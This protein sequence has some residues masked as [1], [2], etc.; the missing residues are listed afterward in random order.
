MLLGAVPA[1]LPYPNSKADPDKYRAGLRGVSRNLSARL[2]VVDDTFP[3]DILTHLALDDG[4]GLVRS[5]DLA[6][7]A[8]DI[9][10]PH[11]DVSPN[12]LAFIQHS[13]GTTG[14]QKGVALT[15]S[16]VMTQLGHLA[17]VLDL[18]AHDRIYSW[19]PLYHDMGLVA[20]FMLPLACHVPVVMQ[21]PLDWVLQPGTM[22][23]LI[24]DYRC[25]VGW[26]PNFALQFLARRVREEDR[27]D[28][29]LSSLRVL[30]NC[31]EPVRAQSIDEFVAAYESCGLHRT[32]LASS[33]AMAENVFA[34]TQSD[35]T[36]APSRLWVDATE[37]LQRNVAV[38][39]PEGRGV[40]LVSSGRC[41]PGNEVRI[42]SADGR[43]LGDY[44]IGEIVIRSDSLFEG[45][46]NRPDLTLE[47]AKEGWYWTGDL[48]FRVRDE[49]FVSGRKRDLI[50]VAGKNIYPHDVEE[51][52]CRHPAI[53][54]GRSVA[55]GLYNDL[56]GTEEIVVVAE[57]EDGSDAERS[58]EIESALRNAIA[59]ELGV[60]PRAI[61]L[62]PTAWIVKSTAGK[63]ARSTTRAKLLKDHPELATPTSID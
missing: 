21:S 13:A 33:Y 47:V 29:D 44:E 7:P 50:I 58:T 16:A 18:R 15:H 40:C 31:S 43:D 3:P 6:L 19:L 36:S 25:T 17:E 45:Y 53:R 62:K 12:S 23:K 48:G 22:L 54:D 51:I 30:V 52:V 34:V 4:A 49:L 28:F 32:A 39:S 60:S 27:S 59:T 14:L 35:I 10:M 9:A 63:P 8:G 57:L 5:C 38:P 11:S 56:E 42:V 55:F 41:L 24:S 61:L 2:T 26:V 1:I 46:F 20:C 37:L